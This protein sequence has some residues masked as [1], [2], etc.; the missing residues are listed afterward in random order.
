MSS[1]RVHLGYKD[2]RREKSKIM[3]PKFFVVPQK[4]LFKSSQLILLHILLYVEKIFKESW[5]VILL[6]LKLIL[7]IA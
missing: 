3:L 5:S 4:I 7:F 1:V 6:L 2:Y